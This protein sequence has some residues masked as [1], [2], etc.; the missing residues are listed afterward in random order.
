M[1]YIACLGH[2]PFLHIVFSA[3]YPAS[4]YVPLRGSECWLKHLGP[5]RPQGRP[6]WSSDPLAL[7]SP[8]PDF[9]WHLGS[10]PVDGRYLFL[11]F[12]E[13]SNEIRTLGKSLKLKQNFRKVN[14]STRNSFKITELVSTKEPSG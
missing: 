14:L 3:S 5:C 8:N 9:Y 6:G 10:E 1:A 11:L 2:V 4:C 12:N 7:A 13:N